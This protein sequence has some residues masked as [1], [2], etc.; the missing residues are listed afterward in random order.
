MEDQ[1]LV[2]ENVLAIEFL[3]CCPCDGADGVRRFVLSLS[4]VEFLILKLHWEGRLL[5]DG[6]SLDEEGLGGKPALVEFGVTEEKL[7]LAE[8]IWEFSA[9]LAGISKEGRLGRLER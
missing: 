4:G 3:S 5:T 1:T 6:F 7:T 8:F 2:K 9:F